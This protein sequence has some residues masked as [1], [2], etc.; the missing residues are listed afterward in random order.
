MSFLTLSALKLVLFLGIFPADL[1]IDIGL[2]R[3][4]ICCDLPRTCLV[5]TQML[6]AINGL[7]LHYMIVAGGYCWWMS[8]WFVILADTFW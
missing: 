4:V 3:H 5:F 8:F 2:L 1:L 6:F 7:A